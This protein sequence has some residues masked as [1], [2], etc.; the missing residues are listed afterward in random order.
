MENSLTGPF[1]VG[2]AVL[3]L[4]P[5]FITTLILMQDYARSSHVVRARGGFKRLQ[6]NISL[7]PIFRGNPRFPWRKPRSFHDICQQKKRAPTLH[8]ATFMPRTVCANRHTRVS[9]AKRHTQAEC[10]QHIQT[11]MYAAYMWKLRAA[12]RRSRIGYM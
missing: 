10:M 11:F 12:G 3:I 6:R 4:I 1:Y 7:C 8:L 9:R 2:F 5:I